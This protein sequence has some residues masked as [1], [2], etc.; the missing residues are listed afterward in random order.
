[1]NSAVIYCRISK[2]EHDDRLG[3][4][5]QQ[6]ACRELAERDGLE[7]VSVLVD[8]DVSATR[9]R[10]PAFE[11]L[12]E[13]LKAGPADTVV[14]YHVDRLYRRTADLER[15]VELVEATGAQVHT[16]AA[17][18]LDLTTASGRMVARMLGAAAQHEVERLGERLRDKNDELAAR[19]RPPGGRSPFG[20]GKGYVINE[21]EAEAVRYMA[22]RVLEGGSLLGIARELDAQGV[23]TRQGKRWHHSSVRASLVNPAIAGLRVHRREIAGPGDWEP[24]LDRDLW[25]QVRSVLADPARKHK[26]SASSYLLSGLV[27]TPAGDHMIGRPDRGAGGTP[28]RCYA[29]R[30]WKDN[31]TKIHA[32]VGA[33][34][35]EDIVVEAV[36]RTLDDAALPVGGTAVDIPPAVGKIE[37]ELAELAGLRGEDTITLEEWMAARKPLLA[38]LEAAKAAAGSTGQQTPAKLLRLAQPGAARREWPN[39]DFDTRRQIIKTTIEKVVIGPATRGRW[40]P[41]LDRLH[42]DGGG[43]LVWNL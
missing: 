5:R 38:R 6:K 31:P 24:V 7:V 37:A 8:N 30:S 33:D 13:M 26:R 16:V 29:T 3:V 22:R 12:V 14:T 20:Y 39:L 1:M 42:P 23:P 43:G 36:L 35:L 34:E 17:G 2:D 28:R 21:A 40:T 25:E 41:L 18:D 4:D 19:G 32:S 9:G 27:E 15:L 11:Q 10:R